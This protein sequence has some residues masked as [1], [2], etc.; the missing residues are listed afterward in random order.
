M[1]R[2]TPTSSYASLKN[3]SLHRLAISSPARR[4][5]PLVRAVTRNPPAKGEGGGA[6]S[7]ESKASWKP[8][9][10]PEVHLEGRC[11][12][13][14]GGTRSVSSFGG[15]SESDGVTTHFS[16]FARKGRGRRDDARRRSARGRRG[17]RGRGSVQSVRSRARAEVDGTTAPRAFLVDTQSPFLRISGRWTGIDVANAGPG[18]LTRRFEISGT[19]AVGSIRTEGREKKLPEKRLATDFRAGEIGGGGGGLGRHSEDAPG[20]RSDRRRD[21]DAVCSR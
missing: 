19:V 3:S 18:T 12:C 17:R 16:P 6:V 21:G 2:G 7:L 4:S 10:D 11:S 14:P 5:S 20:A 9:S 1:E 13:E 15:E 8:F